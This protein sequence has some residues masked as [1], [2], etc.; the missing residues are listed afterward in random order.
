MENQAW[1]SRWRS[2]L[3]HTMEI[4]AGSH[5]GDPSNGDPS[6][7]TQRRSKLVDTVEIQAGSHNGEPA[8]ISQCVNQAWISHGDPSW[9]GDP[10]LDLTTCEPSS[11]T[12]RRS[13][14]VPQRRSK[15]VHTTEPAGSHNGDLSWFTQWSSKLVH[16]TEIQAGSAWISVGTSL[17]PKLRC[18]TQWRSKLV[19][20]TDL[21]L[22]RTT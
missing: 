15:P 19:H 12:Q 7:F 17:D 9:T 5:N 3:V 22:V 18:V 4:Q 16:T 21:K 1:I 20:T 8:W 2:K 13:K 6:W 10:S 11:F 14:L